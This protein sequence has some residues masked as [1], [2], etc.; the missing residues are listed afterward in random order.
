MKKIWYWLRCI[1]QWVMSIYNCHKQ[2]PQPWMSYIARNM[3]CY[4]GGCCPLLVT[5]KTSLLPFQIISNGDYVKAEISP[6]GSDTWTD[7]TLTID[8]VETEG[9][10][11]HSYNGSVTDYTLDC[12]AY[13][14]RV[15]AGEMWW[16]EPFTVVDFTLVTNI[17]TIRDEMMIPFKFTEQ[18]FE[19]IPL[20]APCDTFLPFMFST[21]NATSGTITVYLYDVTNDCYV[22]EL[23]DITVDV[24]T[25]A[26]KTYYIHEEE[27]FYPFLE[28]GI[29]KLEIVDGEHS[30]FSVPFDAVCNMNDIPDG[31]RVL[32][33]FNNCV[34]RSESGLIL[35]DSCIGSLDILSIVVGY[36]AVNVVT[37]WLDVEFDP[38]SE[39]EVGDFF[40]YFDGGQVLVSSLMNYSTR[41]DLSLERAITAG[42]IGYLHYVSGTYPLQTLTGIPIGSFYHDITNIIT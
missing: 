39:P 32:V 24:L 30:Y 42:E 4:S 13:E 27:C 38:L 26:G 11:I 7:V 31:S 23:T 16:F 29:Y 34:M 9:F 3:I 22:E 10:Y 21:A 37:I 5:S 8:T 6:Y 36:D 1:I 18:Q 35:F 2:E 17:Y 25:I 28:C 12:G 19:T 20:I 33:D 41:I 14:F 40:V 15:T